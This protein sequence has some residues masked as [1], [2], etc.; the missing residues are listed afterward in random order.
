MKIS[1]KARMRGKT[2]A[3]FFLKYTGERCEVC[4]SSNVGKAHHFYFKSDAEHL[5][6][7]PPNAVTLCMNCHSKLHHGGLRFEIE[8]M[9]IDA[10]GDE[11]FEDLKTEANVDMGNSWMTED[12]FRE[13][14]N[15]LKKAF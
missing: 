9:I 6:Y 3:L 12:W 7:Y 8:A 14:Y 5:R 2:D 11:W 1:P 13:Q 10:K 4:G 15:K